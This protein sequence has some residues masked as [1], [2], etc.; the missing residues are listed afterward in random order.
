MK[1]CGM[2]RIRRFLEKIFGK[3]P[4]RTENNRCTLPS[5]FY[6]KYQKEVKTKKPVLNYPPTCHLIRKPGSQ[7]IHKISSKH[8]KPRTAHEKRLY[9]PN[10]KLED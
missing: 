7:A 2:G 6:C 1:I 4:N 9:K 5:N 10:A 8:F 3:C